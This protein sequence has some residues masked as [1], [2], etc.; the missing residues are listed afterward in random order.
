LE[1]SRPA[2][3]P[4]IDAFPAPR[5]APALERLR[6]ILAFTAGDRPAVALIVGVT[7]AVG[8][9]GAIEP[10]LF[11]SIVDE[12]LARRPGTAL[13]IAVAA[14][15]AL[16]V[17]REAT[18]S[19]ANWLTWRTR[20]RVQ[21]R[22]LDA[23]VDRLHTL[24][25]A[26][27]RAH[28]VGSLL[29]RLDRGVQ[30]V[31]AAFSEIAFGVLPAIVFLLVSAALM[32]RLDWR[33]SLVVFACVPLPAL[34]GVYAAPVQTTRERK[35]LER[36]TRIYAR[37]NEVLSGIITVKS[38]AMEHEEKQRF[39]R[40]VDEANGLV[41]RGV[42]FD[43]RMS[44]A[45]NLLV[46]LTRVVLVGYGALLV[47]RGQI[48]VGTLLAFLGYLG[49]L[50]G[51]VQGL[52]GAYQTVRKAGVALDTVLGILDA[53]EEVSDEPGAA[54]AHPL[55]G[56]VE[57]ENVWFG[58][59]P[60]RFV[61]RGINLRVPAGQMV[62]LVGP[63]GAGKT[64]VAILLQRLYEPQE[65]AI[66]IDGVDLRRMTQR[67]L[68]KQIGVVL[69]DA[70]LFNDTIRANI[71]YGRPEASQADIEAAARAANAH[72]FVLALPGGYDYE[73][74]ERGALLSAGQRQRIAIA[75]ALLRDPP[76]IILD[77]ATSAL[78]AES[79]VAVQEALGRLLAGRTTLVIAHRLSTVARA[80]R[81]VVLRAGRVIEEGTH[82]ALMAEG[83]HYAHL[84]ALQSRGLAARP[85]PGE[86]PPDAAASSG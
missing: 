25:M 81:I 41:V 34:I 73:V 86:A 83:G 52:T 64:S 39:I 17:A 49:G 22:L 38:F 7:I 50:F 62:A 85:D 66:R 6:R 63:S 4:A 30:G 23:T 45:Q 68:R 57:F 2:A 32:V 44:A 55:R 65:G 71:C 1:Q 26:Y 77:E 9:M 37:F 74:G 15:L 8:A 47:M 46:A 48:T 24:S 5:R 27:H 53:E 28:A 36:W 19:F 20:L 59:T 13:A 82:E 67:S 79:E 78:D 3:A 35:L 58:Y 40:Q 11:K 61:L 75:R 10:L 43:S 31:V 33:L 29:T 18:S 42:G 16:S 60:N 21:H 56:D 80:D 76:L 12:L 51:P 70:S 72:D 84:V 14:L 69:Q 54:E